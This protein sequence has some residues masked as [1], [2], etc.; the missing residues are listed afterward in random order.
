MSERK[1]NKI[2]IIDDAR[3]VR[4]FMR[5]IATR[6]GYEVVEA[7]NGNEGIEALRNHQDIALVFCD[8]NMPELD[9]LSM[10][11]KLNNEKVL[12]DSF[13]LPPFVIVTTESSKRL[14]QSAKESGA[15]GW[16]IKPFKEEIIEVMIKQVARAS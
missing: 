6:L 9:G 8:V 14:A 10:L 5:E 7:A 12:G 11:Y 3:T 1:Y 15:K 16:I 13:V 2:L 4:A